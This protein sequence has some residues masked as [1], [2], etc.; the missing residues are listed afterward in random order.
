[1]RLCGWP[2]T[3]ANQPA[4]QQIAQAECLKLRFLKVVLPVELVYHQ[5]G[6]AGPASA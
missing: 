3:R 1:M 4:A 2:Q 5:A 6:F